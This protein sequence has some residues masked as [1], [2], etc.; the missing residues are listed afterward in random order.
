MTAPTTSRAIT[1]E[2]PQANALP[3]PEI[4]TWRKEGGGNQ[5]FEVHEEYCFGE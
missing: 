4:G 5:R 1:V 2:L 3:P